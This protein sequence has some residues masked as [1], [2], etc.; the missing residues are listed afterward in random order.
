MTYLAR[1]PLLICRFY[2]SSSLARLAANSYPAIATAHTKLASSPATIA[3]NSLHPRIQNL[4]TAATMASQASAAATEKSDLDFKIVTLL[5][6]SLKET[7]PTADS[8]QKTADAIV[9]LYTEQQAAGGDA[10]DFLWK[11]W[12]ITIQVAK[13]IPASD[14]RQAYLVNVISKL[15]A[16]KGEPVEIWGQKATMWDDLALFGP[17]MR[18]A[19]NRKS[20]SNYIYP[21]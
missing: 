3:S 6:T 19:W 11:L 18:E 20:T 10:E 9:K 7:A 14:A 1:R 5:E 2:F 8:A 15:K 4:T 13:N 12:T 21:L 16:T 17:C